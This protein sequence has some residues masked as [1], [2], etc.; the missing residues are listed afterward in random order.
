MVQCIDIEI[1]FIKNEFNIWDSF[2]FKFVYCMNNDK[3]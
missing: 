1:T 2:S 3:N